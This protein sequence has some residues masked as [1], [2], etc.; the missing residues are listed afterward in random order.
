[1][2]MTGDTCMIHICGDDVCPSNYKQHTVRPILLIVME[3]VFVSPLV[4]H[5]NMKGKIHYFND[6]HCVGRLNGMTT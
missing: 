3:V 2:G 6:T 1:M 4:I 5:N